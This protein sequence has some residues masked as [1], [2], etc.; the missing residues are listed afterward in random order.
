MFSACSTMFQG[1]TQVVLGT[2]FTA[3]DEDILGTD[4]DYTALENDL[5]SQVDHIESTHPGYDEYRYSLD[6]I[7]HNPYE[8]ASYLTVVFED[9]TRAEVQAALRHLFEQQYELI[10][11]KKWKSAQ[12]QKPESA[13]KRT[14]IRK[15]VKRG[16]K[17][18]NT[19]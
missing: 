14:L 9:Y 4:E 8:L 15:P 6:E 3:E 12:G 16:K 19:R 1:G 5:R 11:K 18:M 13:L 2:S 17:N 7:G 10:L